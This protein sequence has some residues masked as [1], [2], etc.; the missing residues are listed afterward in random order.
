[1][2]KTKISLQISDMMC[3]G[4]EENIRNALESLDGIEET[5]VSLEHK[6]AEVA[7]NPDRTNQEKMSEAIEEAGYTVDSAKQLLT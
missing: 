2:K 3:E 1:M 7:Y 5:N 4:C 6:S